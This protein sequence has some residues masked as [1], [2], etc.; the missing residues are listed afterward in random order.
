MEWNGVF[1]SPLSPRRRFYSPSGGVSMARQEFKDEC[2]INVLMARYQKTGI[3]P[4]SIKEGEGRFLDCTEYDFQRSMEIVAG[5]SSLFEQL[6]SGIRTRCD[7]D[8][9]KLLAF[10]ADPVNREEARKLGILREA[11]HPLPS[12]DKPNLATAAAVS[13]PAD[14]VLPTPEKPK[15]G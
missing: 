10:V 2:D 4:E 7:N 11:S 5:A 14:P 1:K 13:G 12:T 6:P 3:L 15:G 9:V 8:P